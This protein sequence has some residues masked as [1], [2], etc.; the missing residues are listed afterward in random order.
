M[1]ALYNSLP[2]PIQ[3]WIGLA[4]FGVLF[5]AGIQAF[6]LRNKFVS[7]N[8]HSDLSFDERLSATRRSLFERMELLGQRQDELRDKLEMRVRFC[9][10]KISGIEGQLRNRKS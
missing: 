8:S 2:Q 7:G 3:L 6:N 5:Y 10:N 4:V 9:E 1:I